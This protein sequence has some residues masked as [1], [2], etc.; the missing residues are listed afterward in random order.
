MRAVIAKHGT[1]DRSVSDCL[2]CFGWVW[3]GGKGIRVDCLHG[4]REQ[5]VRTQVRAVLYC[6]QSDGTCHM[7]SLMYSFARLYVQHTC[8]FSTTVHS[9]YKRLRTSAVL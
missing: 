7:H 3:V 1:V 5:V 2:P 8:T 9:R 4:D 6:G